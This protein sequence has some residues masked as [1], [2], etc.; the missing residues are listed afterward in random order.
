[1]TRRARF[2]LECV[3]GN[4]QDILLRIKKQSATFVAGARKGEAEMHLCVSWCAR[5]RSLELLGEGGHGPAHTGADV[6][7][8]P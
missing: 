6:G 1:M 3:V 7:G 5:E 8:T 4:P 2:S